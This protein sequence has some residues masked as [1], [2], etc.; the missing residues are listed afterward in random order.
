MFSQKNSHLAYSFG[1]TVVVMLV[2][3]AGY[4]FSPQGSSLQ[5]LF[6]ALGGKMP[7]GLIQAATFFCFFVCLFGMGSLNKRVQREEVA[8]TAKLLPQTEQFVL[9]PED[10]NQVKLNTIE[11]ERHLGPT[12][13]TDLIKQAATK[14]RSSHSPSEALAIVETVS[15]MNR[16]TIEKEFWM[17]NTCQNLIPAFGFLGTVLGMA[18]AILNMGKAQPTALASPAGSAGT[19]TSAV[20]QAAIS[21]GDIQVLI[22]NLGTAFFTTIVAI[23]LGIVVNV[24]MKKLETRVDDLHTGMKRYVVENLVNRIQL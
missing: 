14:F 4:E 6:F 10:V 24:M 3:A 20:P 17:I 2:T 12:L 9:Y 18:A 22:D 13:L 19:A 15:D 16:R 7:D 21:S 1:L 8:Y 11:V 5:T 23:V